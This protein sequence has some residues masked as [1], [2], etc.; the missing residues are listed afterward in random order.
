MGLQKFKTLAEAEQA[1]WCYNPDKKYYQQVRELFKA[2]YMLCPID[3]PPGIYKY[4]TLESA[5]NAKKEWLLEMELKKIKSPV[6]KTSNISPG[7]NLK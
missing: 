5:N 3:F 1:L 7:N 4:K 6:S 2:A